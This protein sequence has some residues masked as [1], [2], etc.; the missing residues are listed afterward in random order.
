MSASPQQLAYEEAYA[1]TG[2][3]GAALT[4][5]GLDV[6]TRVIDGVRVLFCADMRA[7]PIQRNHRLGQFYEPRDLAQMKQY[8]PAGGIFVDCGANVGNHS[9][10][11]GLFVG[12]GQIIPVEP[13]VQAYRLLTANML[14]NGLADRV[15]F[16]AL[17]IGIG[18][19]TEHGFGMEP[20]TRN[21]GGAQMLPGQGNLSIHSGDDILKGRKPDL[22]KIDVEGG[23]LATLAGLS[24]TVSAR[25]PNI[26]AEVDDENHTAFYDWAAAHDYVKAFEARRYDTNTNQMI[27]PKEA[28]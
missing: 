4:F 6:I 7:D 3:S 16:S 27:V 15:D 22:I 1:K 11:A 25:R 21:I 2:L 26:F 14:M 28:A 9:I 8:F 19:R 18:A 17:G 12:A 24:Q 5:E 20:R 10:F 13:N 23:E